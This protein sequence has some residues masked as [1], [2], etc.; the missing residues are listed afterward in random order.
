MKTVRQY[1]VNMEDLKKIL[2]RHRTRLENMTQLNRVQMVS[3]V[4]RLEED[5]SHHK[6]YLD[7]LLAVV[8]DHN[9][10]LLAHVAE[11]QKI[12]YYDTLGPVIFSAEVNIWS[13]NNRASSYFVQCT[14]WTPM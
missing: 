10:D 14:I 7:Q 9:P 13:G 3:I 6:A 1:A 2:P 11:A 4:H 5:L 12:R 8:I